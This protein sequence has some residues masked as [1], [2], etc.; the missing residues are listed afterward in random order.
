MQVEVLALATLYEARGEFQL[1]L[2]QMRPAGLGAL[3]EAFERLKRKL[4]GEGLFDAHAS[5]RARLPVRLASL[6]RRRLLRCAT[7]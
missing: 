7:Y 2:E 4:E 3:Y 5:G 1:T 6:P